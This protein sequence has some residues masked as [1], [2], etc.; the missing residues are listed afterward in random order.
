MKPILPHLVARL[1]PNRRLVATLTLLAL[2]SALPAAALAQDGGTSTTPL[3]GD[4]GKKY[5]FYQGFR[6][7]AANLGPAQVREFKN[8][9]D[10]GIFLLRAFIILVAV[11]ALAALV[12]GGAMYIIALGDE[13]KTT[14]AK[15]IILYAIIGLLVIGA[16]GLMTNVVVNFIGA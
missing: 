14:R 10:V 1:Q 16:A 6:N 2:L 15:K 9:K 7:V 12:L 11:L 3:G 4:D 8:L 13:Q 5:S